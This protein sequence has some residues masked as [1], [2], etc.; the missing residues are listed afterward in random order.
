MLLFAFEILLAKR[1]TVVLFGLML[2][3]VQQQVNLF[4]MADDR[5]TNNADQAAQQA[6]ATRLLQPL[7]ERHR[8]QRVLIL[9]H[10][11]SPDV[12]IQ[13]SSSA[14]IVRLSN[15]ER[16]EGAQ[17][18][19]RLDAMPFED[20]AFDL[21]IIQHLIADGSEDTLTEATRVLA[22]GG[23]LVICGLNY[24]GL[25]YHSRRR[26]NRYPGIKINR[27]IFHLNSNLFTIKH[28]LRSGFL[29]MSRPLAHESLTGLTLPFADRVVLHA[30]HR[31]GAQPLRL[32]DLKSTRA[33]S[34]ASVALDGLR[35]RN[36]SS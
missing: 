13:V 23:D 19:A 34:V 8:P 35:N 5:S 18:I 30:R 28:C 36:S 25:R 15:N 2:T 21:V 9:K 17:I 10:D 3:P 16:P 31:S 1:C 24:Y 6:L 20:V 22:P 11:A 27:T 32:A 29:G 14:E 33:A 7:M 12:V 26:G 4:A